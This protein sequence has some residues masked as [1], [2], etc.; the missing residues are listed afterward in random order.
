MIFFVQR[1]RVLHSMLLSILLLTAILA[2]NSSIHVLTV[3]ADGGSASF[4]MQPLHSDPANPVTKSYFVLDAKAGI[5]QQ[6]DIRIT[7]TGSATGTVTLYAVDATTGQNSGLV[8]NSQ[9]APRNDVGAWIQLQQQQLTLS[10]GQSQIVPF[11]VNIPSDTWSGQHIGGIVAQSVVQASTQQK[12]T[13]HVN[14]QNLSIVAVEV[15]VAGP[16]TEQLAMTNIQA[17]GTNGYQNLLVGL[18]NTGTTLLKPYGT[19]QVTDSQGHVRQTVAVKL[20]TFLPHTTINYPVYT[21]KT[22]LDAGMYTVKVQ[23]NYGHQHTLSTVRTLTIT[24]Q[25]IAQVFKAQG[26]LQLDGGILSS[27]QGILLIVVL[28]LA[29][30]S[31]LFVGYTLT[32]KVVVSV[33]RK[34]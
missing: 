24:S 4:S 21:Q 25:Q 17:G 27:W 6:N 8:Y 29:A 26:P 20:D 31:M 33:S 32:R 9:N 13:F 16:Q 28:V 19:L 5:A 10:P 3:Q 1:Y 23:L 30:G 7:N 22:P 34:K 18:S 14:V 2:Y 12:N 11:Q 15:T